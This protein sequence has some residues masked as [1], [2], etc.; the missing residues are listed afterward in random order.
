M[1]YSFIKF[2]DFRPQP[3]S[4][5]KLELQ[6]LFWEMFVKNRNHTK[7]QVA[8]AHISGIGKLSCDIAAADFNLANLLERIQGAWK[9]NLQTYY[10]QEEKSHIC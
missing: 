9:E 5:A 8:I 10:C 3:D 7:R 6:N 4:K 2:C 1:L